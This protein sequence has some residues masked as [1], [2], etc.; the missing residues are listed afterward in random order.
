MRNLVVVRIQKHDTLWLYGDTTG[1]LHLFIIIYFVPI[2]VVT[3]VI[4][5]T[6]IVYVWF[7]ILYVLHLFVLCT[8]VIY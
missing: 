5:V 3:F 1:K 6:N 7:I 2:S 4:I 8:P